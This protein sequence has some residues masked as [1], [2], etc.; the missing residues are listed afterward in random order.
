MEQK[1]GVAEITTI[2]FSRPPNPNLAQVRGAGLVMPAPNELMANSTKIVNLHQAAMLVPSPAAAEP[3]EP[4]VSVSM[5][6]TVNSQMIS[7]VEHLQ[8]IN[9]NAPR[10]NAM[11]ECDKLDLPLVIA[12]I[13][14]LSPEPEPPPSAHSLAP[15][16]LQQ[17]LRRQHSRRKG[18]WSF[19]PCRASG[20]SRSGE[21]TELVA[22]GYSE[23]L[24][25][26]YWGAHR[27]NGC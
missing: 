9:I 8:I 26:A 17:W 21:R 15:T 16:P 1:Q 4:I 12:A 25:W 2:D 22:N 6:S 13:P 23:Q 3:G 5:E 7:A 19:R 10:V 20:S 14:V 27:V 11:P 24:F 18:T